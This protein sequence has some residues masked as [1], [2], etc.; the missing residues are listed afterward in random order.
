MGTPFLFGQLRYRN[1]MFANFLELFGRK[2]DANYER[3]FIKEVDVVQKTAPNPRLERLI[4][5][6][7]ILIAIKCLL[8]WWA[9]SKYAV[10]I[11]PLWVIMPTVFM[12]ALCTGIYYARRR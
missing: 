8:V 2:P 10:P 12:A 7:W 9:C 3:A 4:W 11:N 6:S 1:K 5:I